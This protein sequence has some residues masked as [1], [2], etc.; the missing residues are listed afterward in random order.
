MEGYNVALMVDGKTLVGRTQDDMNIAA[1]TKD[2]LTKDDKGNSNEVVTGHDV[3]FRATGLMDNSKPEGEQKLTR[4]EIIELSLRKGDAAKIPV[5][6]GPENGA[7]YGGD[8]IIT[9][10]SESTAANGDATYGLDIKISGKFDKINPQANN[11]G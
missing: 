3:T 5:R 10:Y 4:D 9:G 2:S 11:E 1:R 6:Y 7:I 8:G